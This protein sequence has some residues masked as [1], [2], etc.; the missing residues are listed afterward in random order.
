MTPT[1]VATQNRSATSWPKSGLASPSPERHDELAAC[2]LAALA[3]LRDRLGVVLGPEDA[4]ARDDDVGACAHDVGDVVDL[5]PAVDLDVDREIALLD[6]PAELRDLRERAGDERLASKPGVHAHHEHLLDVFQHPLDRL[7]RGGRV[8]HDARLLA[9]L[10]DLADRA[11]EVWA[12]L[13]VHAD[14]VGAGVG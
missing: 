12:R 13:D 5:D 2:G 8:E 10:A 4:R 3:H 7:D 9:E 14:Q 1:W 6:H 11:V